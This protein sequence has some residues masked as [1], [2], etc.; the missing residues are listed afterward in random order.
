MINRFALSFLCIELDRNVRFGVTLLYI[1][2]TETEA[3]V[4]NHIASTTWEILLI[5]LQTCQVSRNFREFPEMEHDL[6]VSRKCHTISRN[7]GNLIDPIFFCKK[8]CF[9]CESERILVWIREMLITGTW[10]ECLAAPERRLRRDYVCRN[11]VSGS[12]VVSWW[13]HLRN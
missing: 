12:P 8:A 1:L 13:H 3:V 7:L 2:L 4:L 5:M 10:N 6:Q 11:R 9:W